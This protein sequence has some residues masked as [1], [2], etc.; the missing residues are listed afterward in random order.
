VRTTGIFKTM[1]VRHALVARVVATAVVVCLA[2]G[3]LSAIS[4][5]SGG[6][7]GANE[8]AKSTEASSAV[9]RNMAG[10]SQKV[11]IS[12]QAIAAKPQPW[13]LDT[14]EEAVRSYLNWTSYAYR[15]AESVVATPTMSDEQEVRVDSYNQLN[16]QKSQLLDQTLVAITFGKA[17]VEGT[18]AI[19]PAKEKWKYRYVSISEVGKTVGGPYDASYDTTYT[20][21]KKKGGTWVVDDI[22]VK[23]TG[24]IK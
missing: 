15:I 16:L 9:G 6:S 22:A 8:S 7:S 13:V 1:K 10:P 5:C 14:P 18:R 24:A 21:I 19:L 23:A 2:A 17:S 20:L 4:G 12:K 11:V 3:A